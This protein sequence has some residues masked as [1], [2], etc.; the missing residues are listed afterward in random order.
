M[1]S[2]K[3]YVYIP[4]VV[5]YYSMVNL[6]Q[7]KNIMWG[8]I[9][10]LH[11][12]LILTATILLLLGLVAAVHAAENP[13]KGGVGVWW[14]GFGALVGGDVLPKSCQNGES[15]MHDRHVGHASPCFD[16]LI[17]LLIYLQ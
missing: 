5:C 3:H 4:A 1:Y 16:F 6:T 17:G 12:G 15:W 10:N 2:I 7:G 14:V 9:R 13:T 11:K 8:K